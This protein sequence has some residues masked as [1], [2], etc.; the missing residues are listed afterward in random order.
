M[1]NGA[2]IGCDLCH[3]AAGGL[4]DFGFDSFTYTSGGTV[5]WN[6]EFAD[7]DSDRDGYANGMELGDPDGSWRIGDPDPGGMYSLP[8][9]RSDGLCGNGSMEGE[10]ECEG[11]DVGG[12]TC[13][14]MGLGSGTVSCSGSCKFDTSGCDTCG[15]G[16]LQDGEDCDGANLGGTTCESLAL[17]SGTVACGG[18]R[19]DSSGC[20]GGGPEETPDTCGDGIV[21]TGEQCDVYDH[22]GQTCATL[23]FSGGTLGCAVRC[24]FDTSACIGGSTQQPVTPDP[25]TPGTDPVDDEND[26]SGPPALTDNKIKMEGRACSTGLGASPSGLFVLFGLLVVARRRQR[27]VTR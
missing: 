6:G 22:A 12:A 1:P 17:G 16:Q 2:N 14:A 8:G 26:A 10:E 25:E 18:C 4:N 21:Q 3:T 19:I 15:D 11:S 9:D 24:T 13:E 7:K 5:G 23:G 27:R 20:T